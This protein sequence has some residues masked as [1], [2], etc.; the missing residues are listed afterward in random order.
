MQYQKLTGEQK[1]IRKWRI[2]RNKLVCKLRDKDHSLT[3]DEALRKA[4]A[5]LRGRGDAP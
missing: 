1:R 2:K 3:P 5:I 4:N